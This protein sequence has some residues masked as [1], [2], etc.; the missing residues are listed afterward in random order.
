MDYSLLGKGCY[1]AGAD[2]TTVATAAAVNTKGAWTT[3]GS[4][5]FSSHLNMFILS[6]G[7]ANYTQWLLDVGYG[8]VGSENI[9]AEN[10]HYTPGQ[11][12]YRGVDFP[13]NVMVGSGQRI[14]M[15]QQCSARYGINCQVLLTEAGGFA[16]HVYPTKA[17]GYGA[18]TSD[19]GGTVV[20][21]GGTAWTWGSWAELTSATSGDCKGFFV[22]FG[23]RGNTTLSETWWYFSIGIGTSGNEETLVSRIGRGGYNADNVVHPATSMVYWIPIPDGSRLVARSM[24]GQTD[25]TDRLMDIVVVGIK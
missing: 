15:R 14:A 17:I 24:S 19:S 1:A 22:C 7:L 6:P 12:Y 8:D 20:D 9:I 25:A 2:F 11:T 10:L 16:D 3:V 13:L 5:T 4:T 23:T 18:D 21:P